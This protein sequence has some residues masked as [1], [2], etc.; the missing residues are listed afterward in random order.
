MADFEQQRLNMVESQIRPSNITDRRIIRAM[1]RLPREQF[2]TEAARTL[3]YHDGPLTL[4]ASTVDEAERFELAPRDL[5]RLIHE[6]DILATD[7]VLDVGAASGYS[8]AV[9][10]SL[11][12]TV[13]G[14]EESGTLANRAGETLSALSID[15]A[16]IVTGPLAE[17]YTSSGPY[18]VIVIEGAVAEL[19]TP[20]FKQLKDGGRLVGIQAEDHIGRA[21]CWRKIGGSVSRRVCFEAFAPVLPGFE[22]AK[23]FSF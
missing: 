14:L 17:G 6:A 1:A 19:P 12:D 21:C 16:A 13:I 7:M 23:E 3:A 8:S 4:A 9:L 2:L 22:R 10:A 15:N 5:A 18:D 11:C 20:L